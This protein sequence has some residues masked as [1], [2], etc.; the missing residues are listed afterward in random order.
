MDDTHP[1]I[2]RIIVAGL[3][4][5]SFAE[6][7]ER[8][9]QLSLA[10]QQLALVDVRRNHPEATERELMLRLASRRLDAETM[11]RAFGWDPDREGY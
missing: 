7:L 4:K 3:Q 5:M 6:K 2:D 9:R 10:V 11:R 1:E 8:V